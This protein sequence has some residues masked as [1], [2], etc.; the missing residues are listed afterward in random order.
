ME[1]AL[2]NQPDTVIDQA[3][4]LFK[5]GKVEE[6]LE[7]YL[8]AYKIMGFDAELS[9]YIALCYYIQRQFIPALKHIAD[10]I[11]HGIREYPGTPIPQSQTD[12]K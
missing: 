11:E 9:Y 6:A 5:E 8:L 7:Q 12:L 3:S 4:I 2:Q 10:I 1:S